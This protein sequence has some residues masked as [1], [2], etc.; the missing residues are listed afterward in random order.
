MGAISGESHIAGRWKRGVGVNFHTAYMYREA[1]TRGKP[2]EM[3]TLETPIE[4][5]NFAKLE[6][7][8]SALSILYHFFPE[9]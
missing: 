9:A 5:L 7:R 1:I 6:K 2:V 4:T 8:I 3:K